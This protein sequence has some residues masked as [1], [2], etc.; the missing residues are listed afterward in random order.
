[1]SRRG[2]EF[3][4]K[5]MISDLYHNDKGE[6]GIK[7][8]RWKIMVSGKVGGSTKKNIISDRYHKD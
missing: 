5:I 2:C 7:W 1:V 8:E 3:M 6:R 4:E